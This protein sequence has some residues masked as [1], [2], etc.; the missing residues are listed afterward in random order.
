MFVIKGFAPN[1]TLS[2]NSENVINPV[3]ELSAQARTYSLDRGKYINKAVSTDTGLVTF[4]TLKNNVYRQLPGALRDETIRI[5]DRIYT[6]AFEHSGTEL[7]SV[8]FENELIEKFSDVI[9]EVRVGAMENDGMTWVPEW[10]SWKSRS[11]ASDI[12]FWFA[13]RAFRRQYP[14]ATLKVTAPFD[15]VDDFFLHPDEVKAKLNAVTRPIMGQRVTDLIGNHPETLF[16]IDEFDYISPHNDQDKTPA[17]FGVVMYGIAKNNIDSI[18]DAI[19]DYLLANSTHTRDEWAEIL[20]DIFKRTEVVIVPVW[21]HIAIENQVIQQGVYS[22][23]MTFQKAMNVLRTFVP[24]YSASHVNNFGS[25]TRFPYRS[26]SMLSVG[27]IENRDGKFTLGE[28]FPQWIGVSSTHPD[29]NRQDQRTKEWHLLLAEC[30]GHAERFEEFSEI[31][32]GFMKTVREDRLH[33]SF[34]FENVNYVVLCKA[35]MP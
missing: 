26:V 31:P 5:C 12:R 16:R 7:D 2:D 29:F 1:A 34:S 13:E 20:P 24:Y 21:N 25:M 22:P 33:L 11:E 6:F 17:P 10:V 32:E 3:G 30:I 9:T 18:K 27:S 15:R 28:Y 14:E 4:M 8:E 35:S 19:A 23:Q